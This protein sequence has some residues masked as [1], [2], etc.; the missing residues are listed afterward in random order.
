MSKG[1]VL[2]GCPT[3]AG[4]EYCIDN[5][6]EMFKALD[7]PEKYAYQVDNTRVSMGYFELLKSKGI[8]VSHLTPWLD[9]DRTFRRCWEMI[10]E[11]AKALDC[12]WVY[13]VEADNIPAPESLTKMIN[14]A[15]YGNCH[16]VTHAYPMHKSA[17]EASGI[18]ENAWYYHELGCMLM[19]RQLLEKAIREFDD[20]GNIAIAIFKTCDRYMGGYIKLTNLFKVDHLDGYE[21]SFQ[22]LGPS[23]TPGLMCPTPRMPKDYGTV[24]PP[25]LKKEAA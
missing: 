24:L 9:W 7:Y 8:D 19:S 1:K 25:S 5:W 2:V 15:M 10:L 21:M 6:V 14:L 23:E 11:R 13:S 17:A 22:N 3:Y 18:P 16:L 20:Y 4:K 12:Y